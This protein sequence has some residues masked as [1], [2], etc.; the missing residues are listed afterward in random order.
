MSVVLYLNPKSR[1]AKS[2]RSSRF[3]GQATLA[4]VQF[5]YSGTTGIYKSALLASVPAQFAGDS[6]ILWASTPLA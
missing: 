4:G 6:Q 2:I 5:T 1:Y 3:K